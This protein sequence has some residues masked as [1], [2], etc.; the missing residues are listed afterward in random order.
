MKPGIELIIEERREQI[1]KHNRSIQ[2]DVTCNDE[3]QL[4]DAASVLIMDAPQEVMDIHKESPPIGWEKE[5]WVK[6][7]NKP[8]VERLRVAGAL[9]A[10][11]IDRVQN[12]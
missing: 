4:T 9:I 10:A 2:H 1:S 5:A 8:Y 11:E 7:L 12:S 3:Y 6:I